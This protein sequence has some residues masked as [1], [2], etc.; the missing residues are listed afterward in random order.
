M[1]TTVKDRDHFVRLNAEIRSD[2]YWW[3]EFMI[4]WNRVGIIAN[5]QV[6]VNLESDALGS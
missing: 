1:M 5:P 2:L 6:I 3:S 4:W